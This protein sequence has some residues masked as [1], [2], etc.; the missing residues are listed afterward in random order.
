MPQILIATEYIPNSTV[1]NCRDKNTLNR[2]LKTR[3]IM[4]K[5]ERMATALNIDLIISPHKNLI[6]VI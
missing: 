3:E 5:T 6:I 2:K 1:V 4:L